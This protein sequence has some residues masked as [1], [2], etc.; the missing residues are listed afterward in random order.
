MREAVKEERNDSISTCDKMKG[1]NTTNY[2]SPFLEMHTKN[3]NGITFMDI[4]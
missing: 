2:F 4:Y 1:E 3:V